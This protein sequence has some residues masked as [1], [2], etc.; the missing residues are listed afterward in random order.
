VWRQLGNR[1]FTS[2]VTHGDFKCG[3]IIWAPGGGVAG[4]IDWDM[5]TFESLPLVDY[6]TYRAWDRVQDQGAACLFADAL[7]EEQGEAGHLQFCERV[8]DLSEFARRCYALITLV[9]HAAHPHG[10][11][12]FALWYQ[13][14]IGDRLHVA[15]ERFL[16]RSAESGPHS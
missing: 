6:L 8:L 11:P 5:A 14:Y 4:L 9:T 12:W 15:C 1:P 2:V 10:Q 3:N 7:L 13:H 16:E